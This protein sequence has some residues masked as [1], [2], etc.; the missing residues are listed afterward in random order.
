MES[1][2]TQP[3]LYASTHQ[4]P[5]IGKPPGYRKSVYQGLGNGWIS[6]EMTP[7]E[8]LDR[9]TVVGEAIAPGHY[10]PGHYVADTR[11]DT[12]ER[13]W[14]PIPEGTLGATGRKARE[15]FLRSNVYFIDYDNESD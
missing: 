11:D 1:T 8:L 5:I 9:L 6:Q 3:L 12:G 2:S 13:I 14:V 10:Q 4:H 15:T 7:E